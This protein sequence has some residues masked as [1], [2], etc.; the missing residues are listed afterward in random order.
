MV[1][2]LNLL[3]ICKDIIYPPRGQVF[4]YL[5]VHATAKVTKCQLLQLLPLLLKECLKVGHEELLYGNAS[6]TDDEG[7][8]GVELLAED[9][10]V[11]TE[12]K[13]LVEILRKC[14]GIKS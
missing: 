2:V 7:M 4:Q 5:F 6:R 10:H 3:C 14:S 9:A 11:R 12:R 8:L 1:F 13:E